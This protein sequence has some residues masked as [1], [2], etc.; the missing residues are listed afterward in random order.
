MDFWF[1]FG[2][3]YSYL[4]SMRLP[5][6]AQ[7]AG[8]AVNYRPFLLGPIFQQQGWNDSPFVLYPAKGAYMWK[9][10]AREAAKYGLPF[11]RPTVFP[12]WAILPSRIALAHKDA[13]WIATFVQAV[14]QLNFVHDRDID[15]ETAMRE[16]LQALDLRPQTE[17]I[18]R[19]A[20]SYGIK[21]QLREQTARAQALGMFG[22]PNFIVNDEMFWGNDRL[23]DALNFVPSF[24]PTSDQSRTILGESL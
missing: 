1:E 5:A 10:M 24:A 20:Q 6:L 21:Q 8:M 3:P 4:S 16:V 14:M 12:R 15:N 7:Q 9:D 19:L 18:I 22:A 11:R 2:S 17:H 13:P 23:T